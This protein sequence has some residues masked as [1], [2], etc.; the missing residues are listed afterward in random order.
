MQRMFTWRAR[1]AR[2]DNRVR[3]GAAVAI[4]AQ[5]APVLAAQDA[6]GRADIRGSPPE[7]LPG[8]SAPVYRTDDIGVARGC[9][10]T[11]RPVPGDDQG[12]GV[13]PVDGE[14]EGREAEAVLQEGAAGDIELPDLHGIAAA[15]GQP[16]QAPGRGGRKADRA[17]RSS[18]GP[19]DVDV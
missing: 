7:Y 6:G 11:R 3:E 8:L 13:E 14:L 10:V 4:L 16:H 1:S 12:I 15:I 9:H 5:A 19:P 2:S 17:L 18:C